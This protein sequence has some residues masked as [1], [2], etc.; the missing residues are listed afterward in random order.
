MI[1]TMIYTVNQFLT[2]RLLLVCTTPTNAVAAFPRCWAKLLVLS[3]Q[4]PT[5]RKV[6][7]CAMT[8]A[9]DIAAS[10]VAVR[11]IRRNRSVFDLDKA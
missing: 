6:S 5:Y 11:N 10:H 7:L 1:L 2:L 4:D 9:Y 3:V 8:Q